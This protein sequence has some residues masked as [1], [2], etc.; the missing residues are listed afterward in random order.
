M[1]RED[2]QALPD[3]A[4]TKTRKLI[5]HDKVAAITG[6]VTAP[7]GLA[8]GPIVN[9]LVVPLIITCSAGDDNTQRKRV[10]WATRIGWTSSQPM[11]PFGEWGYKKLGYKKVAA[12]AVDFAFGYENVGGFQRTFEEGGGQVI[13]K[14]WAPVNTNDFAPYISNLSKEVD[15]VLA[16]MVGAMPIMKSVKQYS[17]SGLK[18][19]VICSGTTVDEYI[20]PAQGDEVIGYISLPA[21]AATRPLWRPHWGPLCRDFGRS[22][23]ILARV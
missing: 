17:E 20:L 8:V 11:H 14:L 16:V 21:G 4:V 15:A 18:L 19:P 10:K 12:V 9:E 23:L 13:Q 6:L 5:T 2:T 1:I 3:R 22:G 7:S